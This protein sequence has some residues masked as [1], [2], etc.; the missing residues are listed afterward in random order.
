MALGLSEHRL[1]YRNLE[2]P[3]GPERERR[4][5]RNPESK[6]VSPERKSSRQA[7][8]RRDR[9]KD[10]VLLRDTEEKIDR[11]GGDPSKLKESQTVKKNGS[12]VATVL[13]ALVT[14]WVRISRGFNERLN[15]VTRRTGIDVSNRRQWASALEENRVLREQLGMR[16]FK[17]ETDWRNPPKDPEVRE[18][19]VRGEI[20]VLEA[21]NKTL[22]GRIS[23]NG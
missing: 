3:A 10:E 19:L 7:A 20:K 23:N 16:E 17:G 5:P 4:K 12:V 1:I 13:A 11:A 22:R 14:A 15:R 6:P 18:Q 9:A 21:E 8:E 2:R